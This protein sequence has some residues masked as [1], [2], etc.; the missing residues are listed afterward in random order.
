MSRCCMRVFFVHQS[1]ICGSI[2]YLGLVALFGPSSN[3]LLRFLRGGT[4]KR[5]VHVFFSFQQ[6]QNHLGTRFPEE[7]I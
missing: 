3:N 5:N 4:V 2:L 6:V 1:S 7:Q